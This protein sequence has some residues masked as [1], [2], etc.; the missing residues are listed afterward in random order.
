MLEGR[1]G[2][3]SFE[4]I[5]DPNPDCQIIHQGREAVRALVDVQGDAAIGAPEQ[6]LG[7][8]HIDSVFTKQIGKPVSKTVPANFLRYAQRVKAGRIWRRR[9]AE[10]SPAARGASRSFG[11]R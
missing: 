11:S 4:A 1:A 2:G 7:D 10:P 9:T 3:I 5:S 8:L 6:F